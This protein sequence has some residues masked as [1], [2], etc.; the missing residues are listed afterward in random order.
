MARRTTTPRTLRVRNEPLQSM[1]AAKRMATATIHAAVRALQCEPSI[2]TTNYAFAERLLR[3]TGHTLQLHLP[4]M[5]IAM[6]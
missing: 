1:L 4:A 5:R 2:V 3:V 6:A